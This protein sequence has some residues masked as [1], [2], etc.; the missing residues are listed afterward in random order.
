MIA[1]SPLILLE[2]VYTS[3]SDQRHFFRVDFFFKNVLVIVFSIFRFG[4]SAL[5]FFYL[6][7]LCECCLSVLAESR[8]SRIILLL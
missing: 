4:I 5:D 8:G 6:S 3:V 7:T 1:E 2:S